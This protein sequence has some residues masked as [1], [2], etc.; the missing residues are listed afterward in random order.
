[1]A[2]LPT[3]VSLVAVLVS[4]TLVHA[5][6]SP[7]TVRIAVV[8]G[9]YSIVRA[10]S[11]DTL[12]DVYLRRQRLWADGTRAVP[13]NL[14][15]GNPVRERFSRLVLG[16]STQELVPYWNARYFEGIMPPAVLPSAAAIRAYLNAEPGSIAYLPEEDVDESCRRLMWLDTQEP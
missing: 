5:E 14:P 13:V 1:M 6:T 7:P 16:R 10:V 8:V 2:P 4:A 9:R 12:R 15:A 11:Q 3:V